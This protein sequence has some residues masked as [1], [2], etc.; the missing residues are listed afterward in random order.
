M[1]NFPMINTTSAHFKRTSLL[2]T[3]FVQ[4]VELTK[5]RS[6]KSRILFLNASLILLCGGGGGFFPTQ[7]NFG[8]MFDISFP[9]CAFFFFFKWRLARVNEFHSLGQDQSTEAQRA[10]MAVTE[11]SLPSSMQA[12]FLIDYHAL[13]GQRHSQP[14][15]TS[16]GHG[17]MRV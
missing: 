12:R 5:N 3:C 11:C 7:K 6:A 15:P 16:M 1:F 14:T 13:P 4:K 10:E 8:R 17:C 2:K 9:T